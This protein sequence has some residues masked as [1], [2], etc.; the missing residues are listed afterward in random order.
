MSRLLNYFAK[1]KFVICIAWTILFLPAL[2][3]TV[4]GDPFFLPIFYFLCLVLYLRKVRNYLALP[5]IIYIIFMLFP[6]YFYF[7]RWFISFLSGEISFHEYITQE[8][9]LFH[10]RLTNFRVLGILFVL[11][12]ALSIY[13]INLRREL[14]LNRSSMSL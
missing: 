6:P 12:M 14:A 3:N 9:A 4:Y 5:T 13:L 11:L 10:L 8:Y 2:A 7:I 1:Y